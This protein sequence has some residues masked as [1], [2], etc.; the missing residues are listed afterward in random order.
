[1]SGTENHKI[2]EMESFLAELL[3]PRNVL[4]DAQAL[5]PFAEDFTEIERRPPQLVAYGE[6]T[7]QVQ[8][9]VRKAAELGV[10]ITPSLYRTNIGG[11]TLA[12]EGGLILDLTRMNRVLE[13]NVEDMY[14]VIEPGVTQ[15]IMRDYLRDHELPLTLGYSLAPPDT[16]VFANALLGGLTNRSLRYGDQ[17][18]WISGLEVVLADGS[19]AKIG[20]WALEGVPP[21]GRVPFPDLAGLFVAWQGTTGIATRMAFQLYPLH[22]LSERVFYLGYCPR[23]TFRAVRL[24]CHKEVCEDIGGLSWPSAKMML[25]VMNPHPY[26]GEGEPTYLL[27]LDLV[28]EIPEQMAA[29]KKIITLAFEQVKRETGEEFEGPL[30]IDM[31]VKVNPAMEKFAEF[32]TDLDFLTD[33]GG[34]GL[35]WIGT[36]GPLSRFAD[37]AEAA[38]ELM[39]SNGITPCIVSRPM[40]GGHYGVLRFITIFDKNDPERVETVRRVNRELL[41]LLTA[42]GFVMYKTS[43]WAWK[44]LK[45]RMDPGMF[46]LVRRVKKLLDPQRIFNPGKMEL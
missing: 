16:S 30:P 35:T 2:A 26:P 18:Q 14:A 24:L 43:I 1:M 8:A 20:A 5:A 40:R 7:E 37:A 11:L 45:G 6:T 33:H 13:V 17:S 31:M 27:Y 42:R 21:F 9:I 29:K 15:A 34:G 23:A 10:P 12:D 19:L 41:H 28:A 22:P 39:A 4:S 3:G 46:D 25:G 36:Y 38:T 32:P 44:E